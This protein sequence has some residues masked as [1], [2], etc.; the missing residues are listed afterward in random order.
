MNINY[1]T[2]RLP[3]IPIQVYINNLNIPVYQQS[4]KLQQNQSAKNIH[5]AIDPETL[6]IAKENVRQL[7]LKRR[8]GE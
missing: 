8:S 5:I 2:Y 6:K 7:I 4:V 3:I 1:D